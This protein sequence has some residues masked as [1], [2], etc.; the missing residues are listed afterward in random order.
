MKKILPAISSTL[1]T[2]SLASPAFAQ[3]ANIGIGKPSKVQIT[4]IGRLITSSVNLIVVVAGI[5][6]FVYLVW[7]GIQWL[8]S[9]G[10]KTHVQEARD[11]ITH[12]LIGLAIIAAAWAL[13]MIITTF[14]GVQGGLGGALEIGGDL[15]PY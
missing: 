2:L 10:D 15:K 12:A 8:T 3:S 6:V 13:T 4:D 5:L 11:K 9:G 14:L 1:A 7:G